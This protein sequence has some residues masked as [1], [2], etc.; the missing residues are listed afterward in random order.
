[1][2]DAVN[3]VKA[4]TDIYSRMLP[5]IRINKEVMEKATREGFLN[6]TDLADYLVSKDVPFREAHA[7]VGNAVHYALGLKKE[8]HEL[9]LMELKN[10]SGLISEDIFSFLDVEN[11]VDRRKSYG[12]TSKKMVMEAIETA[13]A[14][15]EKEI[16]KH[17]DLILNEG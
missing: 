6:A 16:Q 12:G 5:N 14:R 3:T 9:S 11:M 15:L 8:L 2:F 1:L 4:C 10:F 7:V 17:N 13:K